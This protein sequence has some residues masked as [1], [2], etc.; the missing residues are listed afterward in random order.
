MGSV[1]VE[2]VQFWIDT[3]RDESEEMS[4][5]M[6]ASE[7]IVWGFLGKPSQQVFAA[8]GIGGNVVE[9]DVGTIS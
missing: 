4:H 8:H 5:R 3:V 7:N 1:T 2:M 9:V 6:R